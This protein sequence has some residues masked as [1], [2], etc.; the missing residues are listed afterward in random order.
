MH[1]A[2]QQADSGLQGADGLKVRNDSAG[3]GSELPVGSA[4]EAAVVAVHLQCSVLR[5]RA[6][7]EAE[8]CS[9]PSIPHQ[10]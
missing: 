2:E 4:T 8:S 10:A 3:R 5:P 6:R 1:E 7:P 9:T